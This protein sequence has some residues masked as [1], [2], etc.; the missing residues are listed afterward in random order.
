M[1]HIR[2]NK[3]LSIA[4]YGHCDTRKSGFWI[5]STYCYYYNVTVNGTTYWGENGCWT[6]SMFVL[7]ESQHF[8]MHDGGG[9]ILDLLSTG[10]GSTELLT[11]SR[12]W[13]KQG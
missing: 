4:L 1:S 13:M 2:L 6:T 12:R 9:G 8:T 5:T 11:L 10:I 3:Y 7:L